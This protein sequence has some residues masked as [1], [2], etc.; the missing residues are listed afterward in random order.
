M[1]LAMLRAHAGAPPGSWDARGQNDHDYSF[2]SEGEETHNGFELTRPTDLVTVK[3]WFDA[4]GLLLG[5][6]WSWTHAQVRTNLIGAE[7]RRLL[8]WARRA[9]NSDSRSA[10]P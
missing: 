9:S 1:P 10:A 6:R 5:V 3:T 8:S 4:A 2:F 7:R